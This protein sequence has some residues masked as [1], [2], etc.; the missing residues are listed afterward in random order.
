LDFIHK[1]DI[2]KDNWIYDIIDD[3]AEQEK[4]LYKDEKII[5]MPDYKYNDGSKHDSAIFMKH[6]NCELFI[7]NELNDSNKKYMLVDS[8]YDTNELKI[9]LEKMNYKPI[10]YPNNRNRKDKI[11]L[12]NADKIIYKNRMLSTEHTYAQ[13]KTH[14]RVNCRYE[15]I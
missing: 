15:K 5:M 6:L 4:I 12:S 9:K 7:P 8:G 14:R 3:F 11:T 13:E 2:N 1:H 10:I